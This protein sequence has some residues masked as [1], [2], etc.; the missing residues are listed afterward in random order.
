MSFLTRDKI[1]EMGFQHVGE[2]CL[3]S[4]KA[5][6]YNCKNISIGDN[7][8]IDDFAVLSAGTGGIEIGS[9]VHIAVGAL[10]IGAAKI[11]L[12]DFCGISSRVS[13][14]SSN[15][16]YS[17]EYMT[18]PMIPKSFTNVSH[19]DVTIGRHVIIGSGSVVLPGVTLEDGVAI[20]A[21]S[22]VNK[23]CTEFGIYVGNPIKKI[24]NRSKNILQVEKGLHEFQAANLNAE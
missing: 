22:L 23:S 21:L 19:T 7:T 6:Y 20:G 24:K 9:Y 15:D 18:N 2:N 13:V 4:D 8:R 14:Y 17:G 12:K 10:L 16:D 11:A 3:L 5:S 1:L